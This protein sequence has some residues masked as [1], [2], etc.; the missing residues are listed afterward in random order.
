MSALCAK[1]GCAEGATD[2]FVFAPAEQRVWRVREPGV[3][4]VALCA[5]HAA[6]FAVPAGWTLDQFDDGAHLNS[7]PAVVTEG[8]VAEAPAPERSAPRRSAWFAPDVDA[9]PVEEF[10][11]TGLL[12]RA[13]RGPIV[14]PE[15]EIAE[16]SAD[17]EGWPDEVDLDEYGTI[18]LPFPPAA[19]G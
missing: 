9:D 15:A 5:E 14:E 18:Q 1:P 11:A 8:V 2:W 10:R 4:T 7:E 17:A 13:F 16:L 19:A 12:A 6:R 3:S